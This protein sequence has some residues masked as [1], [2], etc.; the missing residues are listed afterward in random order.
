MGA[1]R[2]EVGECEGT[3][4]HFLLKTDPKNPTPALSERL[5]LSLQRTVD[6]SALLT[7]FFNLLVFR[8][9]PSDSFN[10][11]GLRRSQRRTDTACT[12]CF[13]H[14][15][16]IFKKR[17]SKEKKK[18]LLIDTMCLFISCIFVGLREGALTST[19]SHALWAAANLHANGLA[20]RR[21]KNQ[22]KK[23][24]SSELKKDTKV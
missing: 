1:G 16:A 5:Q 11:R 7:F 19:P 4:S 2:Q 18:L 20:L 13:R 14:L 6:N 15:W 23:K 22:V 21:G 24:F 9:W 10:R 8:C 3:S 12:L 17:K